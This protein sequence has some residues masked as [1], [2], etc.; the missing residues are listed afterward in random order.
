M[1]FN[2][3]VT[4][5]Q[6]YKRGDYLVSTYNGQVIYYD[7]YWTR[8]SEGN[9][10]KLEEEVKINQIIEPTQ[11]SL[12][13]FSKNGVHMV[14]RQ[15]LEPQSYFSISRY[16]S[17]NNQNSKPVKLLECQVYHAQQIEDCILFTGKTKEKEPFMK[18]LDTNT[19]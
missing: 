3:I 15:N 10:I 7:K 1:M 13:M 2:G 14:N 9:H 5:I 8:L 19:I 4:I 17:F 16:L 11:D 12:Y 6:N 18:A